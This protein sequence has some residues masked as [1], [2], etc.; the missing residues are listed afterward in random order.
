MYRLAASEDDLIV[1]QWEGSVLIPPYGYFLVVRTGQ[2]FGFSP[3]GYFDQSLNTGGGGLGLLKP[4]GELVDA[5]A[6]GTGPEVFAEGSPAP[7][8]ENDQSIERKLD[9]AGE[10]RDSDDDFADFGFNPDPSPQNVTFQQDVTPKVQSCWKSTPPTR[11]NREAAFATL[12]WCRIL[13][14]IPSL[15]S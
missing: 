13:V 12:S 7:A 10:L 6:W 4:G 3:D 8:L 14:R 15:T 1:M 11:F 9:E 5:I 2:D